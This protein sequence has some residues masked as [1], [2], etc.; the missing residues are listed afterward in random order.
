M[1]YSLHTFAALADP[2]RCLGRDK[3]GQAIMSKDVN[4]A[5]LISNPLN[6]YYNAQRMNFSHMDFFQFMLILMITL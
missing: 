1:N 3:I 5:K 6:H 2:R 4:D